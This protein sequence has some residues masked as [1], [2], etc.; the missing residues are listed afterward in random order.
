MCVPIKFMVGNE[1]GLAAVDAALS[2]VGWVYGLL[3]TRMLR[4]FYL[5]YWW[6]S[7][8]IEEVCSRLCGSTSKHWS[9]TDQNMEDCREALEREFMAW[10]TALVTFLYFSMLAFLT[11]KALQGGWNLAFPKRR[12]P[13]SKRDIEE[14]KALIGSAMAPADKK[15]K[16][17]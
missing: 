12:H 11:A 9:R 7:L 5:G 3:V 17:A 6:G 14:I 10:D 8:P 4:K 13:M 2:A 1:T 16:G 15:D